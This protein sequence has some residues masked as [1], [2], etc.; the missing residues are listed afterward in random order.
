VRRYHELGER[1]GFL[2]P[3]V[4]LPDDAP[5]AAALSTAPCPPETPSTVEPH[6]DTVKKLL[7][8]GVEIA[9]IWHRLQENHGYTGGYSSVRRFVHRLRPPESRA[10]VCVHT[11]PGEEVQVDFRHPLP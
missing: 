4:A 3:D 8:Q 9:A 7:D 6:P 10:V 2:R 11:D 5:L 1:Q